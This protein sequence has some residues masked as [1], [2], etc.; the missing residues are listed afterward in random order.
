MEN[1]NESITL[2]LSEEYLKSFDAGNHY[3]TVDEAKIMN[4]N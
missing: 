3:F 4:L 1:G 2:T